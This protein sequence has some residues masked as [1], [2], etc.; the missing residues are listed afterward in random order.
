[1]RTNIGFNAKKGTLRG[2]RLPK[3]LPSP[4]TKVA[5]HCG[6]RPSWT[7]VVD[8]RMESPT[9]VPE[10]QAEIELSGG[11][12]SGHLH[13]PEASSATDTKAASED[14]TETSYQ[15]GEFYTPGVEGGLQATILAWG[16]G[17]VAALSV[18]RFS[19][20]DIAVGLAS[21]IEGDL[22]KRMMVS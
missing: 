16:P 11:Q 15:V 17:Q 3:Y 14:K 2:R 20:K 5:L 9:H 10:A 19:E 12:S 13:V 4:E 6:R 7:L 21:E 8:L 22:K 18:R 1:M